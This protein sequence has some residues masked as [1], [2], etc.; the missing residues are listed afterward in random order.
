MKASGTRDEPAIN[1]VNASDA[2]IVP[3]ASA[4]APDTIGDNIEPSPKKKV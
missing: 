4:T 1:A 2:V 3:N